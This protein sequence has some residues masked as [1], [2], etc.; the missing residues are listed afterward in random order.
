MKK[1]HEII[2]VSRSLSSKWNLKPVSYSFARYIKM[3]A[4]SNTRKGGLDSRLSRS[5][6]FRCLLSSGKSGAD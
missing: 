3:A 4:L 6:P 2:S 5:C 1:I